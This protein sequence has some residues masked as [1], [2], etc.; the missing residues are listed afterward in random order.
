MRE[1]LRIP[2]AICC[3]TIRKQVSVPELEPNPLKT[4]PLRK[5][6]LS[7]MKFGLTPSTQEIK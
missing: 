6:V 5:G 3:Q 2:A 4:T 1:P 7:R